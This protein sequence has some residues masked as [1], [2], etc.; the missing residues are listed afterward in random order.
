MNS[1]QGARPMDYPI[2]YPNVTISSRPGLDW[3]AAL[4]AVKVL[5]IRSLWLFLIINTLIHYRDLTAFTARATQWYLAQDRF[6]EWL[7][8]G[9]VGCWL[10][11]LLLWLSVL[12][13]APHRRRS[14]RR[15][16]NRPVLAN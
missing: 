6:A 2:T 3:L 4:N 1:A 13:F 15:R 9:G 14:S 11:A 7:L 8:G 12:C 16:R 10:V 5:A